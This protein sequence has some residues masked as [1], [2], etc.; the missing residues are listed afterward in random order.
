M[1]RHLALLVLGALAA[2]AAEPPP[3]ETAATP[4]PESRLPLTISSLWY[5]AEGK[6]REGHLTVD[7]EG[8]EFV[9]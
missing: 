2:P 8:L 4:S 9:A 5:R 6:R 7:R 3:A 1:K